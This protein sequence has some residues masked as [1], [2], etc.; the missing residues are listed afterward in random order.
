MLHILVG[1]GNNDDGSINQAMYD[2]EA[3][4]VP[5]II[6]I[7]TMGYLSFVELERG[8]SVTYKSEN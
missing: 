1:V 6:G 3:A 2:G 4:N 8:A 7:G 5:G